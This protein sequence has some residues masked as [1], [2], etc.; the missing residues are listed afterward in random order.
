[1]RAKAY[2]AHLSIRSLGA[3][4]HEQMPRSCGQ[5]E[6]KPPV[7]SPQA[8][9]ILIYRPAEGMKGRVDLAQPDDRAPDM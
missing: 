3:E 6:A 1:M 7:F 9:L 4:A 8:S 2:Y 5:S